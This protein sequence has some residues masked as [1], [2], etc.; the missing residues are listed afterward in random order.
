M[1][2]ENDLQRA[3]ERN[4][5]EL[6]FQPIVALQTRN[7]VGFEAL[8]RWRHGRLGMIPPDRFIPIAEETGLIVPIGEWVL[9]EACRQTA[10]WQGTYESARDLI[11]SI[12]VSPRQL[13]HGHWINSVSDALHESGISPATLKVE[14]TESVIM[15]NPDE[16][17]TL[18]NDL[19]QLGA[20]VAI[21]DFGTGYSSLALL[22]RLPLDILK[23]DRSFVNKMQQ[24]HENAAIVR[25][26]ITLASSLNL[27]VIA[28]GIETEEQC[29]Q[30]AELDCAYGQ[31][32]LFS[33]PVDALE[34][35]KI[36]EQQDLQLLTY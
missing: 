21:D 6:H 1:E 30:L 31:G 24:S 26:I 13:A 20:K 15:K 5:L 18:L 7:V 8:I 17:V 4:E 27:D 16:G 22:H 3:L 9:R 10:R 28:E 32:Y 11:A 12:N 34:A 33:R 19:R 14:I 29:Q 2:L 23:V 35:T 25:T 36:L